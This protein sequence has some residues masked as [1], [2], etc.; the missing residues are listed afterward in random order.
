MLNAEQKKEIREVKCGCCYEIDAAGKLVGLEDKE[1][2]KNPDLIAVRRLLIQK[3]TIIGYTVNFVKPHQ[4]NCIIRVHKAEKE[5]NGQK[6]CVIGGNCFVKDWID[7]K[8]R[9]ISGSG[10]EFELDFAKCRRRIWFCQDDY[11][12]PELDFFD[13]YVKLVKEE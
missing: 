3:L 4:A 11:W 5:H 2:A 10:S 9:S 6:Y 7:G 12:E 13:T 1:I 8:W